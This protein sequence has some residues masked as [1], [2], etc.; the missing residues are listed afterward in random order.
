[1]KGPLTVSDEE[2]QP[3]IVL[4]LA[5]EFL[6]RYRKGERPPLREYIQR[7]PELAA[8][9]KEVFPA[10]AMMENIAVAESS[11]GACAASGTAPGPPLRQLGDFRIIRQIG[12]GGMGVV[13]EAEQ[14]SLG[15][16]VALKVLSPQVRDA[17][18]RRRFEREAKAA[19]KLHHTNIV[20]VF[21][22]GEQDGQP[23]YVMQF[24]QGLGLDAVLNELKRLSGKSPET[25]GGDAAAAMANSL[26]TGA[27]AAAPAKRLEPTQYALDAART[28]T[29]SAAGE[30]SGASRVSMSS[31]GLSLSSTSAALP[32]Q[33]GN[34][35]N[36]KTTYWQSVA[37][38]GIQ[39]ASALEYAHKQGVLH[40][41]IK[42][43]NLLLDTSGTVWVTDFGLAKAEG[44]ED[45]THTGDVLGTVRYMPPEAFDG[46]ADARGDVYSLGLTL[47]EMV[48]LRRAFAE[49]DRHHLIKQVTLEE[50]PRLDR[51]APSVPRDLA[52]ILH[53]A[54][55][56]EP[57]R[58]YQTAHEFAEDLQRFADDRPILARRIGA[59]ERAWRWSHRN[60]LSAALTI[61]VVVLLV[62][63]AAVSTVLSFHAT[64]ARNRADASARLANENAL[65]V[66]EERNKA[67]A[68][69]V[70][71]DREA[72][73]ARTNIYVLRLN[74]VEMA[75]EN[76]NV[77]WAL[78]LL[79]LVQPRDTPSASMDWVWRYH[80][81]FCHSELR[82]L[83]GHDGEVSGLAVHPDG[84]R[85]VSCSIDETLREW[86]PATG[87]QLRSLSLQGFSRPVIAFNTDGTRLAVGSG[88]GV[89]K[90]LDATSWQELQNFKAHSR[91]VN[92][93]AFS[94]DGAHL[95]TASDDRTLKM[96]S[97]AGGQ[98]IRTF[99]G[100]SN[101][102]NCVAYSP[103]GQWLASGSE[104]STIRLWNVSTG[105]AVH[106]LRSQA[107]ALNCLA[108]SPD[109]RQ[110]ATAGRDWVVRIWDHASGR[111]MQSLTG[112][113]SEVRAL[114]FSPDGKLLAS[115]GH[116][117]T[118][119][120]WDLSSARERSSYLGHRMGLYS[121]VFSPDGRW[122]A[123][124]SSDK[125][126]RLWSTTRDAGGRTDKSH[127]DQVRAVEFSPDGRWLASV[128]LDGKI[129]VRDVVTGQSK[130]LISESKPGF[131]G[132]AF[133]PDGLL[134]TAG[135]A[136]IVGVWDINSGQA[137]FRVKAH[138]SWTSSLAFSPDGRI[139]ATGS[140]DRTIHLL[141][142]ATGQVLKTLE[143]HTDAIMGLAFSSDGHRLFSG[144]L[145]RSITIWDV[146]SG[147]QIKTLK[148]HSNGVTR[149][150]LSQDN[151]RLASSSHDNTVK[152]WDVNS[153]Q[154]LHTLTGHSDIVWSVQF[155]AD[156]A[157]LVTAGFDQSIRIWD[158]TT[159]F[160]LALLKGHTDR[161]LDVAVSPDRGRLASAGGKDLTVR[162]WDG[163]PLS[164]AT[165]L[166]QEAV[167]VLNFLF[168]RPLRKSEVISYLHSTPALRPAVRKLA[169]ALA[170][171]YGD[172]TDSKAFHD[173]AWRVLKHPFANATMCQFALSQM[174]AACE[175]SPDNLQYRSALAAAQYRLGKFQKEFI[176]KALATLKKCDANDPTTMALLAM[177]QHW[178]DQKEE[179][180]ATLARLRL[181]K[182]DP[183]A[184]LGAD[185]ETLFQEAGLLIDGSRDQLKN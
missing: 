113:T 92:G 95:V 56:K 129:I 9:I 168:S 97:V 32:G 61:A 85:L 124:G 25:Y 146:D 138:T 39:V 163:R 131:L 46:R 166:E 5:E 12:R 153:G 68:E 122:L 106:T 111:E 88:N 50:P 137:H 4:E 182:Q 142:A 48:A 49:K 118:L 156:G 35:A 102:V 152:I 66:T 84:T 149:I 23:Y 169:V 116:D 82:T 1:M 70:R 151:Q 174:T 109:G 40:R 16:H 21:G 33:S 63:A 144:S 13:Y 139:L 184:K 60:P 15:R 120:L 34:G 99:A 178:L 10:M 179:A 71:A 126:I 93:L 171:R 45:L 57:K 105:Q 52:T 76:R 114:A 170:E 185:A 140:N 180:R 100:H 8:E 160:E 177:T 43:A 17:K 53:T 86:D 44:Q 175:L 145:D 128:G 90:I 73:A 147:R 130:N 67:V 121:L 20:P 173:A 77:S 143:G 94:P 62:A 125:S 79:K 80:W 72:D 69:K 167:D 154:E 2:L 55:A 64:L 115:A 123:S 110:L 78:E 148:G 74:S 112:H 176:P 158:S 27:F 7:H 30:P 107:A 38:I 41:D 104:D 164:D 83:E 155:I 3:E 119:K 31:A 108:F 65:K 22:V 157:R 127:V 91:S 87:Q 141:D 47:Y 134:A 165:Q 14:I 29:A 159:G 96:W 58:R 18:H 51:L 11:S 98:E 101:L 161:V 150:A 117:R 6:E 42:P 89:V 28:A 132:M 162:V 59:I 172:N 24:I 181:V 103:D 37:Q 183:M 75:L 136:G 36:R 133:S 135:D 54:I 19:A 81:R 26:V